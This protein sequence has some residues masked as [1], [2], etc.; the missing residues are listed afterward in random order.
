MQVAEYFR[1]FSYELRRGCAL[2]KKQPDVSS[3][4]KGL[5]WLSLVGS[6]SYSRRQCAGN[7]VFGQFKKT[8]KK[9]AVIG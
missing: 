5:P 7:R 9:I 3:S 2:T 6:G 8:E 4:Q 1:V